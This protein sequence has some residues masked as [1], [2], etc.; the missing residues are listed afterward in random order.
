[1][2]AVK[3]SSNWPLLKSYLLLVDLQRM[4]IGGRG[5]AREA[6]RREREGNIGRLHWYSYS[7]HGPGTRSESRRC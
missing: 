4:E 3:G 1:M 5:Q 2:Q 7:T 6:H